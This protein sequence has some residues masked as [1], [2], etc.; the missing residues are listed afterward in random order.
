MDSRD[1]EANLAELGRDLSVEVNPARFF[2]RCVKCNGSA[3]PLGDSPEDCARA[4]RFG[5]P[6]GLPLLECTVCGQVYW[7]S[8]DDHSASARAQQQVSKLVE[9]IGVQDS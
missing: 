5:A 9:K 6:T 2:S 3:A 4:E 8:R 1:W 7:F